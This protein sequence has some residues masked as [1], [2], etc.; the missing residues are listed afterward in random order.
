MQMPTA[1]SGAA[2]R[3]RNLVRPL[4]AAA[5]LAAGS[6]THASDP[7]WLGLQFPLTDG[8]GKPDLYGELSRM[9]A[10]LALDEINANG[11]AGGRPLEVRLV[12]DTNSGWNPKY[13]GELHAPKDAGPL[14]IWAVVHDNRGG[15]DFTRITLGVK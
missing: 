5:L 6:C 2:H 15:M 13:R 8:S 10:Q 1:L 9:G 3:L 12:N 11:G 7:L 14:Q 4:A